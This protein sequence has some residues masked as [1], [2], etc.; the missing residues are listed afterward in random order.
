MLARMVKAKSNST[1]LKE[2]LAI[3]EWWEWEK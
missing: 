1:L 3:N 2:I